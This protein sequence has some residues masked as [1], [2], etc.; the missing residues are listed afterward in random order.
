M[1]L[2]NGIEHQTH[3]GTKVTKS[4]IDALTSNQ[5]RYREVTGVLKLS[6][7]LILDHNIILLT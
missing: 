7:K 4:P 2:E 6:M 3:T 1:P 5:A